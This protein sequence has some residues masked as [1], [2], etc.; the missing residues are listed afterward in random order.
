MGRRE[1]TLGHTRE[2]G[3][4]RRVCWPGA[5]SVD[6][7]PTPGMGRAP[8]AR[9][10]L[11]AAPHPV[12]GRRIDAPGQGAEKPTRVEQVIASPQRHVEV[13]G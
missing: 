4:Y 6:Q 3:S 7:P 12:P 9:P 10:P 13:L 8:P 2:Q 1:E 11:C 5:S